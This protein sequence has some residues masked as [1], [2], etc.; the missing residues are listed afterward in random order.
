MLEKNRLYLNYVFLLLFRR[1]GEITCHRQSEINAGIF[2][3]FQVTA[4]FPSML[5]WQLTATRYPP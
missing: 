1:G 3:A 2:A 5:S 4:T